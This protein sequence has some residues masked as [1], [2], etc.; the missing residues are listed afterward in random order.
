LKAGSRLGNLRTVCLMVGPN[1][2][3]ASLAA[4]LVYL[5]ENGAAVNHAGR[6]VF[7]KKEIDI[8]H[9]DSKECFDLFCRYLEFLS[10][11]GMRGQTGGSILHSNAVADHPKVKLLVESRFPDPDLKPEIHSLVWKEPLMLYK[12]LAKDMARTH[13]FLAKHPEIK[14]LL[15]IRNPLDCAI[16]NKNL[17]NRWLR[18]AYGLSEFSLE[19]VLEAL[20]RIYYT[21]FKLQEAYPDRCLAFFENECNEE[22]LNALAKFLGLTPDQTWISDCLQV[23]KVSKHYEWQLAWKNCYQ[24]LCGRYFADQPKIKGRFL[25]ALNS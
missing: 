5:H 20:F 1:R 25:T 7:S 6:R 13:D 17:G 4:L 22:F 3:L 15:P 19:S 24:E 10:K 23:W 18:K 16:S 8:W 2:N 12:F 21:F 14:L 9:D 11:R